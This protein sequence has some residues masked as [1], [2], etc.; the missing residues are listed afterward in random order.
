[1][2]EQEINETYERCKKLM[3]ERFRV[4]PENIDRK[5]EELYQKNMKMG[6]AV[7]AHTK[8]VKR[9]CESR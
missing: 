2:T 7:Q 8:L 9:I 3:W 1:M 5:L 4:T 6:P